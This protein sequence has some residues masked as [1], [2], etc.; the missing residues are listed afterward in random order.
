MERKANIKRKGNVTIITEDENKFSKDPLFPWIKKATRFKIENI[1]TLF[2]KY[3]AFYSTLISSGS[4]KNIITTDNILSIGYQYS[5]SRDTI[6]NC[7]KELLRIEEL[8]KVKRGIYMLNPQRVSGGR[9]AQA[10]QDLIDQAKQ[11]VNNTQ[12]NNSNNTNININIDSNVS[13]SLIT[14]L[15]EKKLEEDR[16]NILKI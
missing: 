16:Q 14:R 10:S 1:T 5:L 15:I 3:V 6:E 7:I 2:G 9:T 8:I 11:I 13:N 4:D 12:N